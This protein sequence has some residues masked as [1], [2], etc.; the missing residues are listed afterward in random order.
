VEKWNDM[1][2]AGRCKHRGMS[3]TENG[4][5][6]VARHA[7]KKKR[8]SNQTSQINTTKHTSL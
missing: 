1:A 4:V 6:A 2:V 7:A 5:L 8:N 3:W